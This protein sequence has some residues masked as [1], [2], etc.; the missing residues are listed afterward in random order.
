MIEQNKE[1]VREKLARG[2]QTLLDTVSGWGDEQWATVVYSEGQSWSAADILRH[3]MHAERDMTRL[4]ERIQQGESGVPEDFD[5]D[6]WN[7]GRVRK[8]WDKSPA[9]LLADMAA[10][11][12]TLL[13]F[14]DRLQPDDWA[15]EG[16]HGSMQIMSIEAILNR[17]AEHEMYHSW[18]LRRVGRTRI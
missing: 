16:R 13:D 8:G 2:R 14:M 1:A 10:N 3:L 15:K 4:M 6:R 17:I 12:I 11:R 9:E 7:A 18:H 5:L